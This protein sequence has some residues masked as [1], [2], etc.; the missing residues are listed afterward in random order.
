MNFQNLENFPKISKFHEIS[1]WSDLLQIVLRMK[2]IMYLQELGYFF[3][4]LHFLNFGEF[5]KIMPKTTIP[6][7]R[8]DFLELRPEAP[9]PPPS[10]S[11][12]GDHLKMIWCQTA[13]LWPLLETL[14]HTSLITNWY[15]E[16]EFK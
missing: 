1:K 14:K 6:G 9:I 10:H 11:P 5:S 3:Q 16:A 13:I 15:S 2:S 4:N 7:I 8:C 12:V